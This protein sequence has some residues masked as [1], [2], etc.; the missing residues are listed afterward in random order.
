MKFT[1]G[2]D[3]SPRRGFARHP[4]LRLRRIEGLKKGKKKMNF[5]L[6][7]ASAGERVGQRSVVGVS[8]GLRSKPMII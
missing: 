3:D 4:S 7:A 2:G 5:T 6:F 8:G 1:H